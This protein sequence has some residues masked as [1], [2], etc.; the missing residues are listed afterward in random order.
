MADWSE[1]K[2]ELESIVGKGNC[3]DDEEILT[4]YSRDESL[5][6][7]RKP[8]L[9]VK[10]KS[11]AEVQ[12]VV[13]LANKY[14][15][16]VIPRSSGVG[17]YGNGIPEEGGIICDLSSMKKI[18]KVDTRNKWVLIE[19][20]VTFGEL[21][22]E[23]KKHGFKAVNP[24]L[25]HK[26][27]SV[28]TTALEKEP[29]L[30]PK[31]HLDE[32]ILTMEVV[33]PTGDYFR[34]GSMAVPG[35][36]PVLEA[37]PD[38]TYSDLCNSM[39]PGIDWWR[40]LTGCEG[41]FGIITAMNLKTAPIPRMRRL[42]FLPFAKIEDAVEPMYRIQRREIGNEC[43]ILN[44]HDLALILSED[45]DE[46]ESLRKVIPPY[47][48]VVVLD[49]GEWYPEEKMEFQ[50]QALFE[51]GREFLIEPSNTLPHVPEAET[52]LLRILD[53]PWS[54][55]VYWKFRYRG[56]GVSI[57]F[58]TPLR[59]APE[60]IH[61]MHEKTAKYDYPASDLG[62]YI[63]PKQRTHAFHLE[64]GLSFNPE[65]QAGKERVRELFEEVSEALINTGAFF[66]RPYGSWANMV[67]SRTGN[68]N[69][70]LRKVKGILD[71]NN[72]MNPG[73]LSF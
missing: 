25:P 67:Y 56:A 71:P 22:Q 27:K 41:T 70:V 5:Y 69:P 47:V 65:D 58:L 38:E 60:F 59:R 15:L 37:I 11:T 34:T 13:R 17:F 53:Q 21:Q 61:L 40:L 12:G 28:I 45:K 35:A 19:P 31:I 16:P 51:L 44:N 29:G 50:K 42:F 43:F 24:L 23:L 68:L 20:G 18:L 3:L 46:I 2:K 62:V 48:I 14:L 63:Q 6:S 66:Y 73:K 7:Q 33:L 36:P 39:G 72:V 30:S 4:R 52:R 26:E 54:G 64:I 8:D 49:A 32:P 1:I 57:F 55:E 9:V 10:V